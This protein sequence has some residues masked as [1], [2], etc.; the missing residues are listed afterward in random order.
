MSQIV[1]SGITSYPTRDHRFEAC[2][3]FLRGAKAIGVPVYLADT[4]PA[5]IQAEF[6]ALGAILVLCSDTSYTGKKI[7]SLQAAVN[8]GAASIL[9]TEM[10]KDGLLP[11]LERL[12]QPILDGSADLVIPERTEVSWA[13]YPK[14][15]AIERFAIDQIR[16]FTGRYFDTMMGAFV[17]HRYLA[18]HFLKCREEMWTWLHVPRLEIIR[19]RPERVMGIPVDFLYPADQKTAEEGNPAFHLKRLEQ[20]W[21]S[22]IRPLQIVYGGA[23]PK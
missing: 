15:F 19:D 23:K 18:P 22:L 1:V 14:E 7:A 5:D 9:I 3:R 10:E 6:E 17:I 8:G 16:Q 11:Y 12:C 13:S 20:L 4:S 2:Y 21:Y